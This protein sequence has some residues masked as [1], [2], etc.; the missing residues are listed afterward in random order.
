MESRKNLN[1]RIAALMDEL[2][3]LHQENEDLRGKFI[4]EMKKYNH[5]LK[6]NIRLRQENE[7]LMDRFILEE[8]E[9]SRWFI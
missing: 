6:E 3:C 4:R 7:D 8:K 5:L 2:G 1:K 9:N